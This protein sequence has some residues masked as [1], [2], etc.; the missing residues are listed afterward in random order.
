[1]DQTPLQ[2]LETAIVQP[3]L[4]Q[5][6][7]SPRMMVHASGLTVRLDPMPLHTDFVRVMLCEPDHRV[8]LWGLL[9]LPSVKPSLDLF[10]STIDAQ[11][12]P[13]AQRRL[14]ALSHVLAQHI[15]QDEGLLEYHR[16][17]YRVLCPQGSMR[18]TDVCAFWEKAPTALSVQDGL[19]N[20]RDLDD[21]PLKRLC[22]QHALLE[23]HAEIAWVRQHL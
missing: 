19:G 7:S 17:Q 18:L 6:A 22:S 23:H 21:F 3:E 11:F 8:R 13:T 15:G 2:A 1:M 20:F 5:K 14:T 4:W 10:R 9:G 16:G 12:G